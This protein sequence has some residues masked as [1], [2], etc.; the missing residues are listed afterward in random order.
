VFNQCGDLERSLLR[1]GHVHSAADWR[2]VVEPVITRYRERGIN[3][4]F[5]ADAAFANSAI[6][7]K[8]NKTVA[9]AEAKADRVSDRALPGHGG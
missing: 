5:R 2:L 9:T 7:E 8:A 1:P 6:I 3:L 4:Y